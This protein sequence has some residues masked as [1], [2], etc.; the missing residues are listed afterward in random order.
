MRSESL[1][2][3]AVTLATQGRRV[4]FVSADSELLKAR[5]LRLENRAPCCLLNE[6]MP[7]AEALPQGGYC[8]FAA[9][10]DVDPERLERLFGHDG[11]QVLCVEGAHSIS[12][13]SH[14]FRPGLRNLALLNKRWQK[15]IS[16]LGASHCSELVR[17]DVN[18]TLRIQQS[19][20]V[21]ENFEHLTLRQ[22]EV[23]DDEKLVQ[24]VEAL[25]RPTLLLG[26]TP[27][28]V[29]AAFIA[30]SEAQV[31]VHRYHAALPP[32]ER[33]RELL[34]FSLPGRRAVLVATS[35]FGPGPGFPGL[36]GEGIAE[37]FGKGYARGDIQSLVRLSA[38]A[39]LSQYSEEL[40]LLADPAVST[41]QQEAQEQPE[42][43]KPFAIWAPAVESLISHQ[44]LLERKRPCPE[45]LDSIVRI[46]GQ[47]TSSPRS[48][49]F[50]EL[51]EQSGA[52][53]G[54]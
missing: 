28:E 6:S 40:A 3:L 50:E 18:Q 33:A 5:E 37:G 23:L 22:I 46:L 32:A 49:N 12:S 17:K 48:W 51:V 52:S 16:V 30:L 27:A 1:A 13:F 21:E 36:E 9:I 38:P 42:K 11:P 8:L 31:P 44:Q 26:N 39:S 7:P 29:D 53:P 14:E 47:S 54:R 15:L 41:G 4:L 2:H 25:P 45:T 43:Q 34:H 19:E 24:L 35:Q 10:E 20:R